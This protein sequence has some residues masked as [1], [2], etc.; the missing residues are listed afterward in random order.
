M[1]GKKYKKSTHLMQN[2]YGPFFNFHPPYQVLVDAVFCM[3]SLKHKLMTKEQLPVVLGNSCKPMVTRCVLAE[4]EELERQGI[5]EDDALRSGA[6]FVARRFEQRNC[7]HDKP[8]RSLQCL[9]DCVSSDNKNHY[10]IAAQD[11]EL[12]RK[13]RRECIGLP[14]VFL[15]RGVIL[16]EPL[17]R[18]TQE[19]IKAKEQ[20][21]L[22]IPEFEKKAL[23]Q[24]LPQETTMRNVNKKP[25]RKKPKGPNPLSCRKPKK[26]AI[27]AT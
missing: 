20:A 17:T 22:G 25:R 19:A 6:V 18:Q 11:E 4:L 15:N 7:K 14:L 24:L 12:R 13:L 27:K 16:L 5:K 9:M 26:A 1:K 8:L 21:K 10:V 3:E 2:I 23:K